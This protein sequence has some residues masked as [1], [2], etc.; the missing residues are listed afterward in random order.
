[1]VVLSQDAGQFTHAHGELPS[2]GSVQ[3][4]ADSHGSAGGEHAPAGHATPTNGF[5]PEVTVHHTFPSPGLYK[6]WGQFKNADGDVMT[7][8]F[9]VRVP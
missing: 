4:T 2:G 7:A 8:D 5:G 1:M 3:G 9:V 6:L